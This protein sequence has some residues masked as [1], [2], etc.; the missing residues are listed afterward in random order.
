[1]FH[2]FWAMLHGFWRRNCQPTPISLPE[3][4]VDRRAWWATVHG[5]TKSRTQLNDSLSL[6][7]SHTHTHTHTHKVFLF[8]YL[9][10]RASLVAQM[11]KHLPAV[12]ETRVW[13][14]G[15]EDPLEKEMAIHSSTLAWKILWIE[16]PDTIHVVS[17]VTKSRTQLRDF[18][19]TF[20]SHDF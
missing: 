17:V 4:S 7:L 20:F 6:S 13:S 11:V 9:A 15:W 14:L 3:N 2:F 1:M 16:E 8:T 10:V 18:I 12:R 19:F 5:V